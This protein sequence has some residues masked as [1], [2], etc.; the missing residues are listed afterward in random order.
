MNIRSRFLPALALVLPLTAASAQAAPIS[1][2]ASSGTLGAKVTFNVV[3]GNLTVLLENVGGDALVPADALSAVF[4]DIN[5]V[6]ALTPVSAV[7]APGATV[8]ND[9]APAG[10]VVG[11]EWAYA[12]GLAA[13]GSATEGISS[14]GFGLFGNANFPGANLDGPTAVNGMNYGLLSWSDNFATGNPQV[15]AGGNPFVKGG[16]LFTLSGVPVGFDPSATGKISHVVFQYGT[17][18]NEPCLFGTPDNPDLPDVPEPTS[19]TLLGAG[20]TMV[21]RRIRRKA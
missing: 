19:L 14:S 2:S 18:L 10:G 5:G 15:T 16:V 17:G 3:A 8:V 21:A 6:G 4:F 20:L 13:P 11:G 12:S 1:F 7:L 9:S